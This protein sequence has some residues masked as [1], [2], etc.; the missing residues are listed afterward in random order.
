[1]PNPLTLNL[2]YDVTAEDWIHVLGVSYEEYVRPVAEL[3]AELTATRGIGNFDRNDIIRDAFNEVAGAC[4]ARYQGGVADF[5]SNWGGLFSRLIAFET[6]KDNIIESTATQ[7]QML[8][9][10]KTD[11]SAHR[12]AV[13]LALQHPK[14]LRV[15]DHGCGK[16]GLGM[17]LAGHAAAGWDILPSELN[18]KLETVKLYDFKLPS[19]VV[20]DTVLDRLLMDMEH[21]LGVLVSWLWADSGPTAYMF[22]WK[23]N[24]VFSQEVLEHLED[25]IGEL[26]RLHTYMEPGGILY[27]SMFFNSCGGHDPQHL[28]EHEKYQD[29]ELLFSTIDS[30]GFDLVGKDPNGCEK[31]WRKR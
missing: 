2:P 7:I 3:H 1:M 24:L 27:L 26:Q 16:G 4:G 19:R 18:T 11:H 20:C 29:T 25:P 14:P 10:F 21:R 6:A 15:L 17:F 22:S 5:Y 31:V 12:T 13:E 28:D 9:A 23:Y 8:A 30:I